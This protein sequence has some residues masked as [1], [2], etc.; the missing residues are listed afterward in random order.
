VGVC[1]RARS[2]VVGTRESRTIGQKYT[3]WRSKTFSRTSNWGGKP[4]LC[5]RETSSRP[6]HGSTS[7]ANIASR[8]SDHSRASPGKGK[9]EKAENVRSRMTTLSIYPNQH[10][11]NR[12]LKDREERE[13][14]RDRK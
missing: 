3:E 14:K 12:K 4:A 10:Q 7:D 5:D 9:K 2:R 1:V 13:R 11:K 6:R 8:E